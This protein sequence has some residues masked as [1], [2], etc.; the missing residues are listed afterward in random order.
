MGDSIVKHCK[1]FNTS[2]HC[3]PGATVHTLL[4]KLPGLL[5]SAPLTITRVIIHVGTKDTTRGQ[6][7]ITKLDFKDR[8]K[9]LSSCGKS[10]FIS[11]ALPTLARGAERF[12]RITAL[13]TWLKHTSF[14]YN[15]GFIDHFNLFWSCSSFYQ[16]D[17]LHINPLGNRFLTA[18][19]I[20]AVQTHNSPY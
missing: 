19:I 4:N 5:Q 7:E 8:F 20:Y 6:S 9:C 3:F 2:P 10:V 14:Q 17:G 1:F 13:H 15:F 11:G 18:N 16:R 12:S